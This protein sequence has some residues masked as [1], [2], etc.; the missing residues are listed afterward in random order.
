MAVAASAGCRGGCGG[1]TAPG[2]EATPQE[3]PA[4]DAAVEPTGAA[5]PRDQA[6]AAWREA[7][8]YAR[9]TE[10]LALNEGAYQ[11]VLAKHGRNFRGRGVFTAVPMGGAWGDVEAGLAAHAGELGLRVASFRWLGPESPAPRALPRSFAGPDPFPYTPDDVITRRAAA[12]RLEPLEMDAVERFVRGLRGEEA[13]RLVMPRA[14]R[15]GDGAA[16]VEV[17]LFGFREVAPPLQEL[18]IA[19]AAAIYRKVGLPPAGPRCDGDARCQERVAAIARRLQEAGEKAETAEKALVILS[20]AHL[21][22]ARSS[23]FDA[24]IKEVSAVRYGDL[25]K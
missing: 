16:T 14:V 21:W 11:S 18:V 25:L 13:T 10:A 1:A 3:E 8:K 6:E 23:A 20:R 12:L 24:L 9:A 22:D 4:Q 19:D 5:S 2:S 17:V 15:F 7:V